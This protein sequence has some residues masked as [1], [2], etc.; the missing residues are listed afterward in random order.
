M[1]VHYHL[2]LYAKFLL[3]CCNSGIAASINQELYCGGS[4]HRGITK[5]SQESAVLYF[6]GIYYPTFAKL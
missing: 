4:S 5:K 2:E 1:F 6:S 3:R